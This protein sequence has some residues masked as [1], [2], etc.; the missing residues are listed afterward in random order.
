MAFPVL[1]GACAGSADGPLALSN[2]ASAAPTVTAAADQT[3]PPDAPPTTVAPVPVTTV[4]APVTT[5]PAPVTSQA[6]PAVT[7]PPALEACAVALAYL[8]AHAAPGFAHFCR[9]GPFQTALGRT[10]GYT[11]VPGTTFTC[12]D[13]TAEIIIADPACAASYENEASNSFWDF[14]KAGVIAPGVVQ[15]GRTWDPFGTCPS[16]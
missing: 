3:I 11:C 13:G 9:P 1:A 16:T 6:P 4:P 8:N 12:P 5:V 10:F 14:S 7:V 15:N 2:T